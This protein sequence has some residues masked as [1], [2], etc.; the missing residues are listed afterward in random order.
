[1]FHRPRHWVSLVL[2]WPAIG[3]NREARELA[4]TPP[5][6]QAQLRL[7]GVIDVEGA[8][9]DWDEG[10]ARVRVVV[11]TRSD[12][13]ISNRYA[14]TV[15]RLY[16]RFHARG[17]EFALVYVD[18]AESPETIR[19]HVAEYGYPC[20][21]LRDPRHELVRLTGAQVTP[22]A[23]VFAANGHQV[24]RGRI[25]DLF[26]DFGKSRTEPTTH[27]LADAIEAALAGRPVA[28]PETKAVGCYIADLL[29]EPAAPGG[30]GG[31]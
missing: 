3:C 21:A 31:T 14:P 10:P 29:V 11:F 2:L 26:L 28:Q 30:T 6:L 4:E 13:P 22:E 24:Y 15:R 7:P 27:E 1:M 9:A 23:V 5:P 20:R 17:V 19:R 12:C 25:D 16:E 8:Q 18:P